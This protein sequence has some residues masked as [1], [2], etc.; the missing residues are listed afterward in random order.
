MIKN[1]CARGWGIIL[2][3]SLL[4]GSVLTKTYFSNLWHSSFLHF[5]IVLVTRILSKNKFTF[6]K[7]L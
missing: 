4:V 6:L 1:G 2:E 5:I 7:E 3:R